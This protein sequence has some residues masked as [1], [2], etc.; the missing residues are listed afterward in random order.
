[1]RDQYFVQAII[2]GLGGFV[3]ASARFMLGGLVHRLI[4]VG[5]FPLGTSVV[6]VLGCLIIGFLGGLSDVHQ[7]M[8]PSQR[9]F[10][11]V[12][13][14]GGF[15]TF[16]TFA[17]DTLSLAHSLDMAKAMTNVGLH[18]II[19]LAAAWAGYQAAHYV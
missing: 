5:T 15:T 7:M 4:D 1:M 10:L 9:L 16:S 6:N 19:G 17:Y 13:V 18:V 14:L 11:L 3:G 12:G 2:V 8:G